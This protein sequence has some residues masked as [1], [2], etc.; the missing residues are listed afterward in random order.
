ML[1]LSPSQAFCYHVVEQG[2]A[3]F[4]LAWSVLYLYWYR[5]GLPAYGFYMY[6][7]RVCLQDLLILVLKSAQEL[8][9]LAG[10]SEDL[11][12]PAFFTSISA[13]IWWS[14]RPVVSQQST[15]CPSS[16]SHLLWYSCLLLLLETLSSKLCLHLCRH[17]I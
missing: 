10:S 1:S 6:K 14:T 4:K 12:S 11:L 3:D 13:T 17:S 5:W 16:W 8:Q 2:W 15:F 7:A 9:R